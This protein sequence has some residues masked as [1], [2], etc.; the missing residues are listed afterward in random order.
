M[1]EVPQGPEWHGFWKSLKT[2]IY[3]EQ[4]RAWE[5]EGFRPH[6]QLGDRPLSSTSCD[7]RLLLAWV[8]I[9][10]SLGCQLGRPKK[11][12]SGE[13]LP[14]RVDA[15]RRLCRVALR[16]GRRARGTA[17]PAHNIHL[18]SCPKSLARVPAQP[19]PPAGWQTSFPS[20]G[21]GHFPPR[22]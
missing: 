17:T 15:E 8:L 21:I 3:P 4:R 6:I 20:A 18:C 1:S 13:G 10:G 5:L 9:L 7:L 12:S 11:A 19:G 16:E 2:A 14:G 22:D